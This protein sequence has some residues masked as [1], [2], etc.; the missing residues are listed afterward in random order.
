MNTTNQQT[1][2]NNLNLFANRLSTF[3]DNVNR[4][5]KGVE[6]SSSF[7]FIC[8]KLKSNLKFSTHE[9]V[10]VD[11]QGSCK[12][13]TCLSCNRNKSLYEFP[14][15]MIHKCRVCHESKNSK[16]LPPR[17]CRY[18]KSTQPFWSFPANMNNSNVC[19]HCF[20][21][22]DKKKVDEIVCNTCKKTYWNP[23]AFSMG[24]GLDCNACLN[25]KK[26]SC[27]NCGMMKVTQKFP[28]AIKGMLYK[29]EISTG[30]CS[31]CKSEQPLHCDATDEPNGKPSQ[32]RIEKKME[33][34]CT[35][36][37]RFRKFPQAFTNGG[38][39]ECN[40]CLNKIEKKKIKCCTKCKTFS[41]FPQSFTNSGNGEC[42]SCLNRRKFL[43]DTCEKFLGLAAFPVECHKL[44]GHGTITK[45]T[46][47]TCFNNRYSKQ[48]AI[49]SPSNESTN[50]KRKSC[51]T[52]DLNTTN[53]EKK[54][55]IVKQNSNET[56]S[57]FISKDEALKLAPW[58]EDFS[59]CEFALV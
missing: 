59:D 44:F 11:C 58:L 7:C 53:V 33:E 45:G 28:E 50:K 19:M 46:C 20:M 16:F 43:C 55:K 32:V 29:G 18:C 30:I 39:N 10:C 52:M 9:K 42:N 6:S 24:I 4:I 36:C 51:S 47:R 17:S 48:S 21:K 25:V 54:E 14:S 22:E 2:K 38:N 49:I 12:I 57:N 41:R 5:T 31:T 23:K 13:F 40:G 34:Y 15:N 56:E 27:N 1:N 37:K 8:A 35:I 3:T 26:F